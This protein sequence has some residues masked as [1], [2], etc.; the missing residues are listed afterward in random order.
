MIFKVA[1]RNIWRHK[2]RSTVVF[3]AIA[4]G[5]WA[6]LFTSAFTHGMMNQKIDSVIKMEMSHFQ[7][8]KP[9]F[10]E[11]L[12]VKLLMNDGENIVQAIQEEKEVIGVSGRIV[13]M[14]MLGSANKNGSVRLNGI[15]PDDESIV[16]GI[17]E[18]LVEGEYFRGV[19]R[20][21]ILI[22]RKIAEKYKVKIKSK[23]VLTMQDME[24]NIVAGAFKVV[25]L[26]DTQNGMYDEL[27][28]FVRRDDMARL[29][30]V[31]NSLHEIAVLLGRH[32]MAESMA[33]KYQHV[34]PKLEVLPWMDLSTG[35]RMMIEMM[36][37]YTFIIVGII[38]VA[39]LFS[40]VNTMLM[41]VLERVKE[42]GMLMSIGMSKTRVFMMIVVETIC[43][44]FLGAPL[45]ILLSYGSIS[46][47]GTHG[48]NLGDAAYADMGFSNVIYPSL[49]YMD[50][51]VVSMMVIIMAV[52]AAIYP[53][54]KALRLK[55]V[56][57]I[58]KI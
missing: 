20:N 10:R 36:D 58:R 31:G 16:T 19:E 51:L 12:Q 39:L 2:V 50:Y 3:I 42:I 55:P 4:L 48:I 26:F 18:K 22:S 37:T 52:L 46:Y 30:G 1:W 35:M 6:G 13:T 23:V 14:A 41:A 29:L 56:E 54:I 15:N 8:H 44:T 34:Y 40:I 53:A 27:N 47:F 17:N 38:L 21:P 33:D 28:V 43:L 57:A 11:E 9:G 5:L 7:I 24:G 49:E 32:D 25:G 45:G